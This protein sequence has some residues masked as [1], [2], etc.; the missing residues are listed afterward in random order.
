MAI[1]S[2]LKLWWLGFGILLHLSIGLLM[3]LTTF[4]IVMLG[5]L[6]FFISDAEYARLLAWA[7]Q[8]RKRLARRSDGSA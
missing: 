7:R 5:L 6:L 4:S 2:P 1:L 3:G 8:L